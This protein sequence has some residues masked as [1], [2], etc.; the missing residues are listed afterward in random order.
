MSAP[1][2][3]DGS[4][5]RLDM[6]A[7]GEPARTT[8]IAWQTPRGSPFI[9]SPLVVGEYLYLLNDMTSIATCLEART[10]KTVWQ[11]RLGEAKR[12]GFSASP[13]FVNGKLFFTND[14]GETFVVAHAREFKLLHVNRISDRILATPALVDGKWYIRTATQLM[15]IGR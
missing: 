3:V 12:E 8:R 15:A 9:P 10:G 6:T 13:V 7:T 14:D 11:G 1:P 2:I 4:R 5:T